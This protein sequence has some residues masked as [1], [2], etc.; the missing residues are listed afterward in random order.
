MI[1]G[2]SRVQSLLVKSS[3]LSKQVRACIAGLRL[4]RSAVVLELAQLATAAS[5]DSATSH[6]QRRRNVVALELAQ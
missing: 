4:P 1:I 5:C 2:I 6:Q 3:V